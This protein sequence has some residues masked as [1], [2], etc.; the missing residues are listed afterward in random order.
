MT[1][2]SIS[3]AGTDQKANDAAAINDSINYLGRDTW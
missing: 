3:Y 2:Y 1:H